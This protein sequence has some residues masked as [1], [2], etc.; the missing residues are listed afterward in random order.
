MVAVIVQPGQHDRS[1]AAVP[2]W[3]GGGTNVYEYQ[4]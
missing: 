4:W 3:Q 1:H 2:A